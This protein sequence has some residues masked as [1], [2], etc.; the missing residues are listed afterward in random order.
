MS[1]SSE[2]PTPTR[3]QIELAAKAVG[4]TYTMHNDVFE[5]LET[6]ADGQKQGFRPWQPV[7]SKSDSFDLMVAIDADIKRYTDGVRCVYRTHMLP[8]DIVGTAYYKDHNNDKGLAT[9]WAVF[10][11]AVEI[12]RSL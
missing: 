5:I 12:G 9:L 6:S 2:K 1:F 7:T 4:L 8:K 10:L 11:C 3:E